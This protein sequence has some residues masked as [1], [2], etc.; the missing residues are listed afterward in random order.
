MK[1]VPVPDD[2][3]GTEVTCPNCMKTF[4]A[5]ARYT[6]AVIADPAPAAPPPIPASQT[7]AA[8]VPPTLPFAPEPRMSPETASDKPVPPP[9]FVPPSPPVAPPP[10][11]APPGLVLAASTPSAAVPELPGGYTHA[12]GITISPKVIIWLPAVLLT[13]TLFCTFFRWTGSYLGGHPVY[14]QSLWQAV[15][16][17]VSR[18]FALEKSMQVSTAWLNNIPSDWLLLVPSFFLLMFAAGIAW[19]DRGFRGVDPQRFPPIT[20][21]WPWRKALI[22]AL[23]SLAFLLINIQSL[24]GFGMERAI[25]DMVRE[26][27]ELTKARE[28]A[29]GKPADLDEIQY[30]EETEM[31]KYNLERTGWQDLALTCNLL[32]IVTVF[33]SIPLEKRG[34]KPPPKIVL[35]Y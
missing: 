34:N 1:P 13:I 35:H 22:G 30:R 17:G 9:G 12:Y 15:F 8:I 29:A 18:N 23:A 33:L 25:R 4:D 5:P 14:S 11:G 20:R 28:N 32:A 10:H 26:N 7:P 16:A 19:A 3:T 6:P 21:I 27:S 31:R 24:K 2:F